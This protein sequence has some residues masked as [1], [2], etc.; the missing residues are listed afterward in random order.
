MRESLDEATADSLTTRQGAV[1]LPETLRV[2]YIRNSV[3][4]MVDAYDG[5]VTLYAWDTEDPVLQAW[6]NVFPGNGPARCRRSAA[7][8]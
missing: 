4:A 2:N 6:K 5:S 7:T 1:V 3:K 8:S